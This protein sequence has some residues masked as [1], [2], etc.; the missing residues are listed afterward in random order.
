MTL[1]MWH[2]AKNANPNGTAIL[3]EFWCAALQ[4]VMVFF[5]TIPRF[6]LNEF[7]YQEFDGKDAHNASGRMGFWASFTIGS[8]AF[9]IATAIFGVCTGSLI[10]FIWDSGTPPAEGL[11]LLDAQVMTG[12]MLSQIGYP[13]VFLFSIL[14]LH[15]FQRGEQWYKR[16][17][18]YPAMLS[19]CK[20]A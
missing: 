14:Y 8:V 18:D 9:L 11:R 15:C 19:F 12:L 10:E 6:Y 5:G 3:N 2:I 20:L 13:V 4:P 17:G 1:D 7:R 16:G